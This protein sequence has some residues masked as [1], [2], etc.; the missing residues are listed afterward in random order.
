L[1]FYKGFVKAHGC[2]NKVL[3]YCKEDRKGANI[4]IKFYVIERKK[5][6]DYEEPVPDRVKNLTPE[7]FFHIK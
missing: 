7:G 2:K 5:A 3:E 1:T 4:N 6:Y